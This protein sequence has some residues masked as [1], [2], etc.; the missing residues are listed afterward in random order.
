MPKVVLTADLR[1]HSADDSEDAAV[2]S[3]SERGFVAALCHHRRLKPPPEQTK[4]AEAHWQKVGFVPVKS[5][6]I[7]RQSSAKTNTVIFCGGGGDEKNGGG[8]GGGEMLLLL[9]L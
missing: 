8:D 5:P 4:G 7:S 3:D 1:E 9:Q 6:A 2:S